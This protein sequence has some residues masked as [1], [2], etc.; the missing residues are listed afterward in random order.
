MASLA[1]RQRRRRGRRRRW[2][3]A[4]TARGSL[5]RMVAHVASGPAPTSFH[6]SRVGGRACAFRPSRSSA[7]SACSRRISISSSLASWRRRVLRMASAWISDSSK[8]SISLC[9]GLVL[10]ADDADHL[11]EVQ[12]GD[13]QAV[14]DVQAGLDLV[15]AVA[16]RGGPAPRGGGR[17]RPAAWPCRPM[18]AAACRVASSTFML[19]GKRTSRSQSR[20][21]L[22]IRTSGSTVAGSGLQH[23]AD[24]L[25]R[26]VAHVAQQRRPSCS[27][28]ARPAA[29]PAAD[30]FTW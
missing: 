10:V 17:G 12:E 19:T 13:Q 16:A 4:W 26:L 6:C 18:H 9:L 25:G 20:Y 3:G 1:S 5:A 14:E 29:R 23:Q 28:S 27:R 30:F 22:S 24:V 15:E 2:S 21:R 8:A 7:S 11:V